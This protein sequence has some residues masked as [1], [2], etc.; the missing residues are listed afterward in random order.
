M[1]WFQ[2]LLPSTRLLCLESYALMPDELHLKLTLS[3]TQAEVPCPI[4]GQSSDR[5]HSR[6][7]RTLADLPC[8][9][10]RLTLTVHVCKFFCAN[11]DCHRRIFSERFPEVAAPWARK[12]RRFI[13]HLQAIALALGGQAGARLGQHL[14][15]A[16]CG[17]TL[18][19][20]VHSIPLPIP[21]T[22]TI[23]GVDDFALCRGQTYGTI[24]VNLETHQ[25]IALLPDR[26]AETLAR[27]LRAHSGID[28]LSR[29]RSKTYK[30]AMDQAAP[31]AV[32][33]AD[34]FH[35][36]KNLGDALA[37]VL[38]SYRS[39]LKAAEQIQHQQVV[40]TGS[41][42]EAVVVSPNP[43]SNPIKDPSE[44]AQVAQRRRI[45][46]QQTIKHLSAQG[47]PQ[48]AIAQEVGV[49]MRTVQRFLAQPDFPA[50]PQNATLG[51]S[52]LASYKQQIVA[53]W[54]AGTRHSTALMVLLRQ[55][56]YT[57]SK[58]TLERYLA[59]LRTAQGLPPAR[60]QVTSSLPKVV[61][62]QL[63]PLTPHRAACLIVMNPAKRGDDD[64]ALLNILKEQHADISLLIDLS[65]TFLQL[66]RQR[67][68][69]RFDDWMMKALTCAIQPLQKFAE[70]LLND[71]AAV[72][73]SMMSDVSNGP[74]EGLNNKLKMLKR[75]MY[76][77]ASLDLLAKRLILSR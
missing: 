56:G 62:L 3:S 25:P 47:W 38:G 15:L 63:P 60:V 75:Q 22:P 51:Q 66:L 67:Q 37:V 5:V 31:T 9:T 61:D 23:L 52:I 40:T 68:A 17:S 4:C 49:S 18:L 42:S 36:V 69:D 74:V 1:E 11:P 30:R 76:G 32:Q 71:Y 70:G 2:Y 8:I 39:E 27:W 21:E 50:Q 13:E 64:I 65:D 24:L 41:S 20:Q 14:G 44:P 35:L 73:A 53:W 16:C 45:E 48:T 55:A 29:D 43:L 72:K 59:R 19:N 77:R 54:N 6:Y 58:R 7:T 33:V 10:F 28:V 46:Q 26:N 12:T 57:G 34:R